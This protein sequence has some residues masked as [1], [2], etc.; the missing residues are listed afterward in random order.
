MP[1]FTTNPVTLNNGSNHIFSFLAQQSTT[2]ASQT[3]G[4]WVEDAAP[5]E[6]ESVLLIKHD[7]SS[8]TVRRRLLQRKVNAATITRGLR[9]ITINISATYDKEHVVADVLAEIEIVKA[10]LAAAGMTAGFLGG[11]LQ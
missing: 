8:P 10:A 2:K 5:I 3:A 4:T 1:L 11:H 9:P 6:D 7:V